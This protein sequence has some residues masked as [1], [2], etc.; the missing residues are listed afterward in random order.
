MSPN[1][2]SRIKIERE[3]FY[4]LKA[5]AAR[6]NVEPCDCIKGWIVTE[7]QKVLGAPANV[8]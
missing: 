1:Q 8:Q 3:W 4:R 2:Q 5:I 7:E 6:N